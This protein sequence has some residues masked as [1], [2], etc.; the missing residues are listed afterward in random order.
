MFSVRA[1]A[2]SLWFKLATFPVFGSNT[3]GWFHVAFVF[4]DTFNIVLST[5]ILSILLSDGVVEHTIASTLAC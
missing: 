3:G 2:W 1:R 5:M 4:F